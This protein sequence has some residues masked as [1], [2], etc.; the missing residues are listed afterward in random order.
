MS[1][2]P[3][4]FVTTLGAAL[5]SVI[6]ALFIAIQ[7]KVLSMLN[8][9]LTSAQEE[10]ER[11]QPQVPD[12]PAALDHTPSLVSDPPCVRTRAAGRRLHAL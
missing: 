8:W 4:T 10:A 12:E 11:A 7:R 1:L 5:A 6:A 3:S 2:T 9:Q